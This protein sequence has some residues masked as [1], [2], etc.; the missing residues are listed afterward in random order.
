M[1]HAPEQIN[2]HTKPRGG[3]PYSSRLRAH[4]VGL[5]MS[6]L[7]MWHVVKGSEF[8]THPRNQTGGPSHFSTPN[9]AC[10]TPTIDPGGSRPSSL[11]QVHTLEVMNE[12][13]DVFCFEVS[14]LSGAN[15]MKIRTQSFIHG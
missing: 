15:L 13:L 5:R 11:P 12:I 4:P 7:R 8:L 2:D 10:P 1:P 14:V 6:A 9:P 3:E